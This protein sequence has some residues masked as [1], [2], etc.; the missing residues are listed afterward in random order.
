MNIIWLCITSV[1]CFTSVFS[2]QSTRRIRVFPA[3]N[4]SIAGVFQVSH[5]DSRDQLQYAFSA[6]EARRFCRSL[7][8]SI[9]SK[10][11]VEAALRRGLETCRFG[12]IDEH[13]VVIPR[14]HALP[15]CGRNRT[16]LV[17]WR[18]KVTEKF[19]VFCFNESEQM[20]DASTKRPLSSSFYSENTQP[21][22]GVLNSTLT[23]YSTHPTS[24]SPPPSSSSTPTTTN[25]EVEAARSVGSAHGPA[26]AKAALISCT[27]GL[28]LIS[29]AVLAYIKLGR[30][31]SDKKQQKEYIQTEEWTCVKNVTETRKAVQEHRGKEVGDASK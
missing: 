29:A 4:Q 8:L 12:W 3:G 28:I 5:V 15:N 16:G 31:R 22:S 27:C 1:L 30:R 19:D 23:T 21:S 13:F 10:A 7:G 9:A 11:Q 17:P 20:P 18:A 6:S 2:D 25:N 14:I 26:G 24:S